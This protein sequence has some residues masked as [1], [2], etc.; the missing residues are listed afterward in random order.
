LHMIW[1][2][3]LLAQWGV[4]DFAGGIVVHASAG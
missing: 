3:G 4:R 2:N 1:G